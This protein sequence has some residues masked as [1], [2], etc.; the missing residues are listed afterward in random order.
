M[1]QL[2]DRAGV[3]QRQLQRLLSRY[4]G[5]T[6]KWLIQRRRL[7]DP[8]DRL[9]VSH[10]MTDVRAIPRLEP[11]GGAHIGHQVCRPVA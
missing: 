5:L 3:L 9:D 4:L 8:S 10:H 1:A 7:H 11:R 6:P 2:S